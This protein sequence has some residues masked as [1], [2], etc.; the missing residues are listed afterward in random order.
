M[1]LDKVRRR[2][3]DN[4]LDNWITLKSLHVLRMC[5]VDVFFTASTHKLHGST[6]KALHKAGYLNCEPTK[7]G[8][9]LE[10]YL[11]VHGHRLRRWHISASEAEEIPFNIP[12]QQ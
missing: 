1:E 7:D 5:P 2:V 10:Y 8:L 9:G 12:I 11:N 3:Y 4:V 6:L